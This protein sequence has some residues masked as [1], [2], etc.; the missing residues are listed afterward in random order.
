MAIL[1]ARKRRIACEDE[2]LLMRDLGIK[3]END[4][5]YRHFDSK[6]VSGSC[7]D[8]SHFDNNGECPRRFGLATVRLKY[9]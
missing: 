5:E 6:M 8:I 7:L 1:R 9:I 3:L 4:D 2:R